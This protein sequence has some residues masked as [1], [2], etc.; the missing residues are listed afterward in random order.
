MTQLRIQSIN[1]FTVVFGFLFITVKANALSEY[2]YFSETFREIVA[3]CDASETEV[4]FINFLLT[5]ES[6]KNI[7]DNRAVFYM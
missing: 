2:F 3:V 4:Y 7:R 6:R 1:V 5:F